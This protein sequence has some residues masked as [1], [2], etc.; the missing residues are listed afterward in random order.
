MCGAIDEELEEL[1]G[2][3]PEWRFWWVSGAGQDG[4]RTVT[5]CAHP[6]PELDCGSQD[7]LAGTIARITT[8]SPL[9]RDLQAEAGRPAP[10]IAGYR[11]EP[12]P[13]RPPMALID[14]ELAKLR[15]L[16]P[17]WWIWPALRQL[18]DGSLQVRWGARPLP[19]LNCGSRDELIMEIRSASTSVPA[20]GPAVSAADWRP[21]NGT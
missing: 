2:L 21:G 17:G 19:T 3:Y 12:M 14:S 5:W 7:E 4:G 16:F 1:A 15:G 13:P 6:H 20:L 8:A 9:L 10:G 11:R 18:G